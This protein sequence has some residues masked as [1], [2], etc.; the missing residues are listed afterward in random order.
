MAATYDLATNIGKVRLRICDTD[1]AL[2]L[3][4]DAEISEFLIASRNNVPLAAAEAYETLARDRARL[5]RVVQSGTYKTEKHAIA[6][7]LKLA[8]A[9]RKGALPIGAETGILVSSDQ[10]MLEEYRPTWRGIFDPPVVE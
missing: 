10:E 4:S 9:L 5:A 1:I 7:L 2:A 8:D 3:F 6:D